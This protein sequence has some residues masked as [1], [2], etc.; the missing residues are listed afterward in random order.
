VARLLKEQGI[1]YQ[2]TNEKIVTDWA[3]TGTCG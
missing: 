2:L 1:G 3:P